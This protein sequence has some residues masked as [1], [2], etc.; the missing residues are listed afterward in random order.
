[1]SKRRF[2]PILFV[3]FAAIAV[4][5]AVG[6]FRM[7]HDS[8]G[9]EI[10]ARLLQFT[11]QLDEVKIQLG[12][13]KIRTTKISVFSAADQEFI[14]NW[15]ISEVV[16]SEK[17]LI[18]TINK[19]S[20]SSERY[21]DKMD[22]WK[23]KTPGMRV[24]EIAYELELESR[25]TMVL[26]GVKAEYCIYHQHTEKGTW[27]VYEYEESPSREYDEKYEEMEEHDPQNIENKRRTAGTKKIPEKT[28]P[29]TTTGELL[30]P[31]LP[32][33][34][35]YE[36][37]TKAVPLKKG[38]ESR[39][40]GAKEEGYPKRHFP[41][42]G[43]DPNKRIHEERK[44]EGR[45]VGVVFRISVPLSSGGYAQKEYSYPKDLLEKKKVDWDALDSEPSEE[46]GE[47]AETAD[48][49]LA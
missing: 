39:A 29:G 33:K 49:P 37:L 23:P 6:E 44:V 1:M 7:F 45:V 34:G 20:L 8:Q 19:K 18:V 25:N 46:E 28:V 35:S 15:H 43:K 2:A 11:P 14:R 41:E 38:S 31:E 17:N 30:I 26:K 21:R 32:R 47:E 27:V 16:F 13:N 10:K 22:G 48:K 5:A 24:E 4:D 40:L 36:V 42:V 12:N 9:R 3:L